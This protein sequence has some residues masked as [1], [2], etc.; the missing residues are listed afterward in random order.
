MS[1]LVTP[2]Y[3]RDYA[4]GVMLMSQDS[5]PVPF[6]DGPFPPGFAPPVFFEA[7]AVVSASNQRPAGWPGNA[8]I[9]PLVTD[10][11][12]PAVQDEYRFLARLSPALPESKY[13]K[14]NSRL[15]AEQDTYADGV[16]KNQLVDEGTP[17]A[18]QQALA[19]A[20]AY[21]ARAKAYL[22]TAKQYRGRA[23]ALQRGELKEVPEAKRRDIH[24]QL[25]QEIANLER[26]AKT[27]NE[28][29]QTI[30]TT[31]DLN[32]F[33]LKPY[34]NVNNQMVYSPEGETASFKYGNARPF[35][36]TY[37][38][39]GPGETSNVPNTPALVANP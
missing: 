23:N 26:E 18:K 11:L 4:E 3:D 13:W 37:R 22:D 1:R 27:M 24:Q 17:Q 34:R 10:H 39:A 6:T 5:D 20:N 2:T 12:P 29:A 31:Y 30:V 15:Q 32:P 19:D 38:F 25:T 35:A 14:T 33:T 21:K 8:K 36:P 28:L 9:V 16:P 7:G